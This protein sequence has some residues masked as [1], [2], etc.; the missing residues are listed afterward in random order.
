MPK[1][2]VVVLNWN[3]KERII[4]CLRSVFSLGYGNFEVVVVDN[5][6]RDG[7]LETA[8][9]SFGRAH[10]IANEKNA[11]F[12]AG[13][14]VGIRFALSKG[15]EYV[16]VLNNDAVVGKDSLS[17]LVEAA[18]KSKKALLSPLILTPS[19]KVWFSAG[20]IDFL[21]MRAV[22]TDP[23]VAVRARDP[24]ETGYLTGCA[25]FIPKGFLK[26]GGLFDERFFL[27][28][29][30]ADLSLRAKKAG[31]KLL[32]AP[33]AVIVHGEQSTENKE[34][35]YWLVLSGL[36]FFEKHTPWHLRLW[37]WLYILLRKMKNRSDKKKGRRE[38]FLV[39]SAYENFQKSEKP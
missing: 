19:G 31:F 38:A 1:V 35:N 8:R 4:P 36:R 34:K 15:A 21:R 23:D 16:W 3:G 39:A 27:Y 26:A 11:G 10:F 28:Y 17:E 7:S 29:E 37:M 13:M 33:K 5:A 6:S 20:K 24:Y 14:N 12:A 30:D 32:V 2:F 18:M 22:H 25:M 9:S